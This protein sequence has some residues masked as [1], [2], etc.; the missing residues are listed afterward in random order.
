[1]VFFHDQ[2]D[3]EKLSMDD[4]NAVDIEAMQEKADAPVSDINQTMQSQEEINIDDVLQ[5]KV[6]ENSFGKID[7]TFSHVKTDTSTT[8]A[9]TIN[10]NITDEVSK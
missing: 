6:E 4:Q 3:G 9:V 5:L 8:D 2:V 7:E 1:M 10:D